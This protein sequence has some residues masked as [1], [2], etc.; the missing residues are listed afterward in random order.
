MSIFRILVDL[1]NISGASAVQGR[2]IY[3]KENL[4]ARQ[5]VYVKRTE[6]EKLI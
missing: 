6:G 2:K 1:E 3:G 5:T 4:E